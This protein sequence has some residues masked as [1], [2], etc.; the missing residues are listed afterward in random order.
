VPDWKIV[1][2]GYS[3]GMRVVLDALVTV[4]VAAGSAE[5]PRR[6]TRRLPATSPQ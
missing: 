5:R 6:S 1:F 2:A 4:V 3:Q